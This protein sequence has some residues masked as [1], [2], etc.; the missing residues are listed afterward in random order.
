MPSAEVLLKALRDLG[1][2]S[3]DV[4]FFRGVGAEIE[5]FAPAALG[6][7]DDEFVAVADDGAR[8]DVILRE[9]FVVVEILR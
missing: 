4:G 6:A 2:G 8:A 9:D 7:V 1:V 5:E 3:D